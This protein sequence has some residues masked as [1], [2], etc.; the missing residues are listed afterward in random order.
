MI[1]KTYLRKAEKRLGRLED[2]IDR[3]RHRMAGPAGDIKDRL[4]REFV[5]LRTKAEAVRKG[6]RAIESAGAANWGRLK[7]TVED[8]LKEL[9][10]AI[11]ESIEKFRKTGSGER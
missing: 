3:L 7:N 5:D 10:R 1:R 8:G 4:E 2:D 6:F 9:G 11:D